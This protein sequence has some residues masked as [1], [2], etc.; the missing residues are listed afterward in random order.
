MS[1]PGGGDAMASMLQLLLQ[2]LMAHAAS[3]G[4][5]Q[6]NLFLQQLVQPAAESTQPPA[7]QEVA[8]S[9]PPAAQVASVQLAPSP[10]GL[11]PLFR[12]SSTQVGASHPPPSPTTASP[13]NSQA[14]PQPITNNYAP[15]QS[16]YTP[17]SRPIPLPPVATPCR[18][19]GFQP[20]IGASTLPVSINAVHTLQARETS[21]A[22]A[23]ATGSG[24]G[25]A[26][27]GRGR[28]GRTVSVPTTSG[29]RSTS[30][31]AV[32][33]P[34]IHGVQTSVPAGVKP[35]RTHAE[36]GA[37]C[38]FVEDGVNK[39]RMDIYIY[40]PSEPGNRQR[41]KGSKLATHYAIYFE[42]M[43][44]SFHRFSVDNKLFH[45]LNRPVTL[46]LA[47]LKNEVAAFMKA[48]GYVFPRG[49]RAR[50]LGVQDQ[51]L[52]LLTHA[53]SG[54]LG[55]KLRP[56]TG[57]L[58]HLTL[59][60][61][62]QNSTDFP[63][64]KFGKAG[65]LQVHFI[66][67]SS[68]VGR[69]VDEYLHHCLG[70]RFR[71]DFF[72][73]FLQDDV[74]DDG[75]L[76]SCDEGVENSG[77]FNIEE[78][79]TDD[80]ER[81][82]NTATPAAFS[83]PSNNGDNR[84]EEEPDR[85]RAFGDARI[86]PSIWG[87]N[88]PWARP[89]RQNPTPAART[90]WDGSG[91]GPAFDPTAH[92]TM[93]VPEDAL[94]KV[95]LE[96]FRHPQHPPHTFSSVEGRD[97]DDLA[98]KFIVVLQD[99]VRKK[100]F[101]YA[102]I[103]LTKCVVND[104]SSSTASLGMGVGKEVLYRA[105]QLFKGPGEL[106]KYFSAT[107]DDFSSILV[108]NGGPELSSTGQLLV[109]FEVLGCLSILM[110]AFG[111]PPTPLNPL[112]FQCMLHHG[113]LHSLTPR[114]IGEWH[115]GFRQ[116]LEYFISLGHTGDLLKACP[117]GQ[118][119]STGS[120]VISTPLRAH[121]QSYFGMDVHSLGDR[122]EAGHQSWGVALLMMAVF[123]T[124]NLQHPYIQAFYNGVSMPSYNGRTTQ[125]LFDLY[126]DNTSDILGLAWAGRIQ[127]AAQF[128]SHFKIWP[129]E[130]DL[131]RFSLDDRLSRLNPSLN[132]QSL[133]EGFFTRRGVPCVERFQD[134]IS[135]L[136]LRG[137][138]LTGEEL[139][140]P[141]LR[142]RLYTRASTGSPYLLP[143]VPDL[144]LTLVVDPSEMSYAAGTDQHREA[145]MRA[146]VLCWHTCSG[147]AMLPIAYI[148]PLVDATYP[149]DGYASFE[150]A[151]DQW[152]LVQMVNGI[153]GYS[154]IL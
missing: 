28:G 56:Y 71:N 45:A 133:M 81:P 54:K 2:Q 125:D 22:L 104:G 73:D 69:V 132:I 43:A 117:F 7:S 144:E 57:S 113:D 94:R 77:E 4:Q 145:L 3:Q 135:P 78:V 27:P 80:D 102:L 153:C 149:H 111:M 53:Q 16:R 41:G 9:E 23:A 66:I 100:D 1:Q 13:S 48:D 46:D 128:L 26:R 103:F 134:L 30:R 64:R 123:G 119:P 137:F 72:D 146:G 89:I 33:T 136:S 88:P 8:R 83:T 31:R 24:S 147:Q 120:V 44:A 129:P 63:T 85:A 32:S 90:G 112:I 18:R 121:F 139:N 115:P 107:L 84:I 124:T 47:T 122:T 34:T 127:D 130:G 19:G 126:N 37:F 143:G 142:A 36:F 98:Q 138:E 6:A 67:H 49:D 21:A 140:S 29:S 60:G 105:F 15:T 99:C 5:G 92:R 20:F 86:P 95:A 93:A 11:P 40:P 38:T 154:G 42:H 151:F 39:L 91:T 12:P 68:T 61:M 118:N 114:L 101:S 52:L 97:V 82:G 96:F 76:F 70:P 75:T 110:I 152:L 131:E 59:A 51:E 25:G 148:F 79:E 74:E 150:D 55:S 141:S 109:Q 10:P 106:A 62:L 58:D 87:E 17:I 35:P 65:R 50:R 108:P 14:V 116:L